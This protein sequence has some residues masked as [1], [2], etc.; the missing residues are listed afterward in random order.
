MK[1][2]LRSS[3]MRRKLVA[4]V[5][6][7][8]DGDGLE[9]V[10]ARHAVALAD[11]ALAALI[12]AILPAQGALQ[13]LGAVGQQEP[14][15]LL[16]HDFGE[17]AADREQIVGFLVAESQVQI[18]QLVQGLAEDACEIARAERGEGTGPVL[19]E[20]RE[21]L[22]N[23]V[24]ARRRVLEAAFQ[25]VDGA[26]R[27]S[28]EIAA[29]GGRAD[30]PAGGVGIQQQVDHA[31]AP[32]MDGLEHVARTATGRA[33][34]PAFGLEL[35]QRGA[36]A[37]PLAAAQRGAGPLHAEVRGE[38]ARHGRLDG[39]GVGRVPQLGAQGGDALA[40]G[41]DFVGV[42]FLHG[43]AEGVQH[44]R[45]VEIHQQGA[46]K[47]KRR[48]F[49]GAAGAGDLAPADFDIVA[50]AEG[51]LDAAIARPSAAQKTRAKCSESAAGVAWK[52]GSSRLAMISHPMWHGSKRIAPP[53]VMRRF[54]SR[55]RSR[56][57]S[58]RTS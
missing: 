27:G 50:R 46:L 3:R 14:S 5:L 54:T 43:D 49:G 28:E 55:P 23:R 34:D 12:A 26:R 6:E 1:P 24:H 9:R 22:T 57:N 33:A 17:A 52:R 15:P 53:P 25:I 29:Q 51:R 45:D 10:G 58:S 19:E 47:Q 13:T 11:G 40:Q 4:E 36:E 42:E 38:S 16:L 7:I 44:G 35:G 48:A 41:I 39:R 20:L 21:D 32:T 30:A 31:A 2:P 18:G 37:Q 56:Q 8:Q